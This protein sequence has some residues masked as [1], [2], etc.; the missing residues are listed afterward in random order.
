ML[1]LT[2]V[3]LVLPG[4]VYVWKCI[5]F[6][7]RTV[8]ALRHTLTGTPGVGTTWTW[9]NGKW[10]LIFWPIFIFFIDKSLKCWLSRSDIKDSPP[11]VSSTWDTRVGSQEGPGVVFLFPGFVPTE[12]LTSSVVNLLLPLLSVFKAPSP[13][14][15]LGPSFFRSL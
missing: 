9:L 15:S 14:L 8:W 12:W 7:A 3:L 1:T 11:F 4:K 2:L 5:V 6:P 13:G 10:H